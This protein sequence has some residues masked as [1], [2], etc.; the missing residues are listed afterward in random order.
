MYTPMCIHPYIRNLTGLIDTVSI[1][2]QRAEGIVKN[3]VRAAL[4]DN[5]CVDTFLKYPKHLFVH[6]CI[7]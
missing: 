1:D 4:L 2:A 3:D 7:S 5:L 6:S